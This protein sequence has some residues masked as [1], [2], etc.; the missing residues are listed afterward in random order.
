[1]GQFK[2]PDSSWTFIAMRSGWNVICC[3]IL[4]SVGSLA[5]S[6]TFYI[7]AEEVLWNYGPTGINFLTLHPLD[8][9]PLSAP[10]FARSPDR[11]GGTYLK[12]R[13]IQYTDETFETPIPQ[14]ADM[15]ILGPTLWVEEGDDVTVHF[16]NRATKNFT[17]HVHGLLAK[18]EFEGAKYRDNSKNT[19]GDSV[20]PGEKFIY[21][22]HVPGSSGK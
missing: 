5:T 1:M 11:I 17:I 10:F 19:K 14:P 8:E 3:L 9:D 21:E 15:G 6:R 12:A 22:W 18:K 16:Y 4:F 20:P 2:W 7:A 13:Y